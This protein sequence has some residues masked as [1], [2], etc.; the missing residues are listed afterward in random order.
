MASSNDTS[1]SGSGVN[2]TNKKKKDSFFKKLTG[3]PLKLLS[4]KDKS[5]NVDDS[6]P[7]SD[8]KGM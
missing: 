1:S 6:A 5:K 3:S 4:S 7:Q 8:S 2:G